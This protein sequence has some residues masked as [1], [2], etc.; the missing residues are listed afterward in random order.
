MAIKVYLVLV[1]VPSSRADIPNVRV[2]AVSLTRAKAD[3]LASK[4]AGA[5]VQRHVATK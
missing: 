5:F 1:R 2:I 4:T 3:A